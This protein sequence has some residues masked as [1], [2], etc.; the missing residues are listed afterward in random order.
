MIGSH[1]V[2]A[3]RR[4]VSARPSI[5]S[6][7]QRSPNHRAVV[8]SLFELL[9]QLGGVEITH[10]WGG[11][12]GIPRDWR[13]SVGYDRE[14]GVAWAG[15]YVGEGVAAANLAGRTLAQ[16]ITGDDSELARL[17]LG[18]SSIA[19]VGAG[20]ISMVR[21]QL[22]APTH[23]VGRSTRSRHPAPFSMG[24]AVRPFAHDRADLRLSR[25][26]RAPSAT[27][28]AGLHPAARG[29]VQGRGSSPRR[30]CRRPRCRTAARQTTPTR[31]SP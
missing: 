27:R 28:R 21:R 3:A 2:A 19:S 20:A 12:L 25:R 16:L 15:G 24:N 1:S 6:V 18:R 10:Y 11:V 8:A 31:W 9:P 23:A 17:A 14:H 26:P 30:S 7:E 4:T 13:P 5:R 22:D 29:G